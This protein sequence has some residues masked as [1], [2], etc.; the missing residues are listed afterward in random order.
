[1]ITLIDNSTH[2]WLTKECESEIVSLFSKRFDMVPWITHVTPSNLICLP[3][4]LVQAERLQ[5]LKPDRRP[6]TVSLTPA[7]SMVLFISRGMVR[8]CKD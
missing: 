2:T 1:M 7:F 5:S 6:Q 8:L 3:V 4:A